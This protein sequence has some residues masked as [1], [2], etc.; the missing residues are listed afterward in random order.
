MR[1][2]SNKIPGSRIQPYNLPKETKS[3]ILDFVLRENEK[4]QREGIP[5]LPT[6]MLPALNKLFS[7]LFAMEPDDDLETL[8]RNAM[9][10]IVELEKRNNF[11]LK[12]NNMLYS[13]IERLERYAV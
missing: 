7:L 4:R 6:I 12:E 10:E 3:E 5:K 8:I 1:T 2:Q 13:N 11:L 9:D